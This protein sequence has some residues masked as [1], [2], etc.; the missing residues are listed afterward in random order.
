MKA[1]TLSVPPREDAWV[2]LSRILSSAESTMYESF[3]APPTSRSSPPPPSRVSLRAPPLSVSSPPRPLRRSAAAPPFSTS[4]LSVPLTVAMQQPSH[5]DVYGGDIVIDSQCRGAERIDPVA[6]THGEVPYAICHRHP[7]ARVTVHRQ[8]V[9]G[10]REIEQVARGE[11]QDVVA[12]AGDVDLFDA[13]NLV[14]RHHS[15]IQSGGPACQC[16]RIRAI[17]SIHVRKPG[18]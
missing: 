14:V 11:P 7:I 18:V 16:K 3:P 2:P 17:T 5:D 6:A 4:D 12:D 10:V 1:C 9:A 13:G 8:H 15:E